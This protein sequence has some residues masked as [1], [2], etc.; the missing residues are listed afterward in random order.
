VILPEVTME[1]GGRR[2]RLTRATLADKEMGDGQYHLEVGFDL[3]NAASSLTL[4][5]HAMS[6]RFQ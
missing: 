1:I 5:F 3:L 6:L 2:F 4:D